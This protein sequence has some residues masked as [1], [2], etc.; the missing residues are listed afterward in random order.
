[1]RL[2]RA[3]VALYVALGLHVLLALVMALNS[4]PQLSRGV[5]V[6][7]SR[8]GEGLDEIDQ[9]LALREIT[10]AKRPVFEVNLASATERVSEVQNRTRDEFD[11]QPRTRRLQANQIG[12]GGEGGYLAQLRAH[13]SGFRRELPGTTQFAR[14]QVGFT[15]SAQGQ[16]SEL[17]LVQAS[18]LAWL[19]A[20]ALSLI[21]RATPLPRPP[22][23]RATPLVVP[24]ELGTRLQPD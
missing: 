1:M 10:A 24:V 8:S 17:R 22:Q 9:A 16:V 11:V 7:L 18:G 23:G 4:A 5:D 14:A 21:L 15:V 12:G 2:S 20:E 3:A 6:G 13:L 19:D